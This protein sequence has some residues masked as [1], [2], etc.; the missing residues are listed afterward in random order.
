MAPR[1]KTVK[2][3]LAAFLGGAAAMAGARVL[4]TQR[5]FRS[6]HQVYCGDLAALP[7]PVSEFNNACCGDEDMNGLPDGGDKTHDSAHYD[8]TQQICCNSDQGYQSTRS[9]GAVYV[10]N[11][12]VDGVPKTV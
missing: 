3:S 5:H 4:P 10:P 12:T 9:Y 8:N 2:R 7:S 1:V 11:A 6:S